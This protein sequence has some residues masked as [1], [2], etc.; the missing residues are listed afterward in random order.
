MHA[1]EQLL[2]SQPAN[3]DPMAIKRLVGNAKA[4]SMPEVARAFGVAAN[5][6]RQSWR[7]SGMPGSPG[8]YSLADIAIW[9]LRYQQEIRPKVKSGGSATVLRLDAIEKR[10]AALEEQVNK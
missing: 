6:V 9:R 10:L 5:T 1:C 3:V 2:R 7:P 8:N 4:E